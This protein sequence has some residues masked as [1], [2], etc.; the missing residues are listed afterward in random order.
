MLTNVTSL[1]LGGSTHVNAALVSGR[2]MRRR[3]G[4]NVGAGIVAMS[5]ACLIIARMVHY[6]GRVSYYRPDGTRCQARALL[7]P[8]WYIMSGACLIIAQ[9]VRDVRRVPYYRPSKRTQH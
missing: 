5:G 2:T 6:V 7:S 8:G 1:P 9:T 3:F 4:N